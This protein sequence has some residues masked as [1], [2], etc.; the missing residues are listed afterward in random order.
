MKK[1]TVKSIARKSDNKVTA[2]DKATAL[3][4]TP[5]RILSGKEVA[6]KIEAKITEVE[7]PSLG[8]SVRCQVPDHKV[9]YDMKLKA[10]TNEEFQSEL[11]KAVLIDFTAEDLERL[12]KANGIKYFELFSAVMSKTD[13]F[14]GALQQDNIK[15]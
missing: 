13:L 8:G 2:N 9:I 1:E 14:T 5:K 15:N 3:D 4:V 7:V 6:D 12:E 11:F 10:A